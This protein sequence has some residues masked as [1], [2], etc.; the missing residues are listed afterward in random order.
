MFEL[1]DLLDW[2]SGWGGVFTLG[3]LCAL[4]YVFLKG[5]ELASGRCPAC[6]ERR[7][8]AKFPFGLERH[9]RVECVRRGPTFS[10]EDA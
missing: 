4:G 2:V 10:E 1:F 6:G 7:Y 3:I 8:R 9:T 5:R